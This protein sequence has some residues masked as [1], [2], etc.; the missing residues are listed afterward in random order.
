MEQLLIIEGP[1]RVGKTSLVNALKHK[2][3]NVVVIKFDGPKAGTPWEMHDEQEHKSRQSLIHIHHLLNDGKIVILD[4]S[5]IG[6]YV[7]SKIYNRPEPKYL[8]ALHKQYVDLNP[9][10]IFIDGKPHLENA[11]PIDIFLAG[12]HKEVANLFWEFFQQHQPHRVLCIN[13]EN[14]SSEKERND[15][16]CNGVL[17]N[18]FFVAGDK[19]VYA[20]TCFEK[21][22]NGTAAIKEHPFLEYQNSIS[23]M[24][25]RFIS[26]VYH[27]KYKI[28]LF[29]E[30]PGYKGCGLTH[31]PF[32]YD[33]SGM[34]L[35]KI[36]FDIGFNLDFMFVSNVFHLTP[37]NNKL[38]QFVTINDLLQVDF[39]NLKSLPKWLEAE[40]SLFM[41]DVFVASLSTKKFLAV[42][43]IA[44][45]M[46]QKI[47]KDLN[48]DIEIIH[49]KHPA[50]FLYKG[51][52]NAA[53]QYYRE[54][55]KKS[56][57]L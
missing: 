17:E 40:M 41:K 19:N 47:K 38:D 3:K 50:W 1:D 44:E 51:Q 24:P 5:H 6:E 35:R 54:E 8:N 55:L 15:W 30:A 25:N 31:I 52:V 34:L 56:K 13:N 10:I 48:L 29:G 26:P 23:L 2:I 21:P 46:L 42:G 16:V 37:P 7:Y 39:N 53:E 43:R 14:F 32:Y 9:L 49:L 36:F 45:I 33:K 22:N 28:A 11:S 4:R 57:I 20:A 27:G 18:K 12:R